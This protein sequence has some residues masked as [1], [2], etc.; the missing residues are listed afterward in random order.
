MV[1]VPI[2]RCAP[3]SA[4]AS[5]IRVPLTPDVVVVEVDEERGELLVHVLDA[6]DPDAVPRTQ[7]ESYERHQRRVFP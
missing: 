2:P 5:V 7:Q 3:S 4:A 6:R 1:T